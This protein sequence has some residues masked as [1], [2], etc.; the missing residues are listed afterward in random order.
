MDTVTITLPR[1][2]GYTLVVDEDGA[3][4]VPTASEPHQ[5]READPV[6]DALYW[7]GRNLQRRDYEVY[8]A[9]F[10]RTGGDRARD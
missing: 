1:K 8:A 3:R 2:P 9:D 7:Q 6:A 10:D 5:V 4:Y